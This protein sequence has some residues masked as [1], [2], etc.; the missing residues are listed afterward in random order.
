MSKSISRRSVTAA[1]RSASTHR[2][3]NTLS[4]EF[5]A[6]YAK[7]PEDK[8][9]LV[10]KFIGHLKRK[11][12]LSLKA[13][14]SDMKI[15]WQEVGQRLKIVA[16]ALELPSSE[17]DA[18]LKYKGK[19]AGPLVDFARRYHQSLDWLIMGDI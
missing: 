18:A 19:R 8:Q 7:L 13:I 3:G 1:K 2:K 10:T 17:V 15:N 12:P 9:V 4:A 6:R 14:E 16:T 11:D 5:K